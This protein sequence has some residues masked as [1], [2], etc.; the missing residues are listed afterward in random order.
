MELRQIVHLT[1]GDSATGSL[2]SAGLRALA[3][4]DMLARGPADR[5]PAR[6]QRLRLKFWKANGVDT[7]H[8]K[9]I[10]PRRGPVAIW[11]SSQL[12]DQLAFWRAVD[13][14]HHLELWRVDA[15]HPQFTID[16]LGTLPPEFV[17]YSLEHAT[18]MS[19]RAVRSARNRWRA[20]VDGNL[21]RVAAGLKA[22]PPALETL[23]EQLP[24]L[25]EGKL[26]LS[27]LDQRLLRPFAAD[28]LTPADAFLSQRSRAVLRRL[29]IFG[30]QLLLS[31]LHHWSQGPRPGLLALPTRDDHSWK[32]VEYKL[33]EFGKQMLK[34]L[35]RLDEAPPL[36]MGGAVIYGERSW[37][38]EEECNRCIRMSSFRSTM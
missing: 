16:S 25:E 37:V 9:L 26:R 12:T 1:N 29:L 5:D 34:G 15:R 4:P 3:D 7:S 33:T 6:H 17:P 8:A 38:W 31:R 23:R 36:Q 13:R 32:Q 10:W 19:A 30:D 21:G 14:L 27:L 28:W 22:A 11:T 35:K 2:R 18:R 24:R 20:F